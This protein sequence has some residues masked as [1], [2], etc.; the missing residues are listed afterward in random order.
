MNH[1]WSLSKTK[2]YQ[3]HEKTV[4][5]FFRC[6]S[7]LYYIHIS[8]EVNALGQIMVQSICPI[9]IPSPPVAFVA[10]FIFVC[11]TVGNKQDKIHPRPL[12]EPAAFSSDFLLQ[13][14]RSW[15]QWSPASPVFFPSLRKADSG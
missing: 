15:G 5:G 14:S 11:Y 9:K 1:I 3:Q 12:P 7:S 8:A 10:R 6:E 2:N 13:H 4:F